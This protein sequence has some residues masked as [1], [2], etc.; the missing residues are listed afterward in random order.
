MI[1]RRNAIKASIAC[2]LLPALPNIG[3]SR[4]KEAHINRSKVA[5]IV[6]ITYDRAPVNAGNFGVS[7]SNC[8]N[9]QCVYVKTEKVESIT[10]EC[11]SIAERIGKKYVDIYIYYDSV[12]NSNNVGILGIGY[13][14]KEERCTVKVTR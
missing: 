9:S 14:N 3:L 8:N 12:P 2:T 4:E 13:N 11:T 6:S 1:N 5:E 10:D 7:I